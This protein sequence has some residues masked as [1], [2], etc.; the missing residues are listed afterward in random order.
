[1]KFS[2]P[3]RLATLATVTLTSIVPFSPTQATSFQEESVEQSNVIA[4]AR[5][6]GENKY[7]LLVIEQI[8]G[9]E[10][11][12]SESGAEPIVVDPLLLNFDFTGSCKRSTDSNGYSIRIDG[13]DY[14][15]DYLL[16]VVQ[17]SGELVLVGTP[18]SDATQPELI[19]GRTKGMSQ[20]FLK[21]VLEPGWKFSKRSYE[22]KVLGHFY[23]SGTGQTIV[24][25][26]GALPSGHTPASAVA[27]KDIT[28]DIY[29]TEI[30]EAVTLGFIAGFKEDNTFRPL[31]ALTRE[32]L[33]SMVIEALKTIPNS[34][35]SVPAQASAKPYPDVDTT[36]W[37]AAKIAWAQQNQIVTGYPDGTFQPTK[38][39]TRAELIA[40]L[41]KATQYA[42]SQQGLSKDIPTKQDAQTFS[43]T[44][45]HWSEALVTQ[46]SAYC[47]VAS[48]LN[49]TG[50]T[51][52][53]NDP[54]LRNYAAAATLRM[55]NCVKAD[56]QAKQ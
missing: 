2:L 56:V 30:G 38:E 22:G 40:V 18:R 1:M 39:V 55:L 10:Q 43:D 48:P 19:I 54:A 16:S 6:Y 41:S 4:I 47:G 13:Q 23:F 27:F 17:R 31:V 5:P 45:G 25:S 34:N 46:M 49:E 21:F 8:P 53:P 32:Q 50:T 20:G 14:G 37:S 29:K 7:D 36:R 24:A 26:G 52:V 12:W 33:V 9:K 15:L 11:C 3:L 44:S 35:I 51:F 28:D 42:R